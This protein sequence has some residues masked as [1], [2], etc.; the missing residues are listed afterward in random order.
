MSAYIKQLEAYCAQ[1]KAEE[2]RAREQKARTELEAARHRLTPIEDR[3]ARVLATIPERVQRQ[4]LSL[5]SL[6]KTLR[7]RHRGHGHPG[8][9]G[10]ALRKL[11][12]K[13][14]RRWRRDEDGFRALWYPSQKFEGVSRSTVREPRG[15]R[16]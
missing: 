16:D 12:F 14:D 15:G 7:G 6:Q 11:G 3:L 1:R 5:R 4:G 9:I 8:E 2:E 13:R 10:A